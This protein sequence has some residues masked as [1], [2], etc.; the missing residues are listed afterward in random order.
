MTNILL[1]DAQQ[2]KT[3]AATRS[4]GS[5]GLNVLAGENTRWNPTAF[6]KYCT[7]GL[8][9][10][11]PKVNPTGFLTW[12]QQALMKLQCEVLLPMD[13]VT[14]DIVMQHQA[15][16]EEQ[17]KLLLP[18]AASFQTAG[19]KALAAKL[20]QHAGIPCPQT[21]APNREEDLRKLD[22]LVQTMKFPVVLKPRKSSGSR[23]ITVVWQ[24]TDLQAE[25]VKLHSQ[26]PYPLIQEYISPGPRYDVCLLYN[27]SSEL[28][29]S[30]VQRELRHFP[31]E[32][33]PSTLQESVWRPDLV[34]QAHRLMQELQ[35]QG[36]AE[37]EFMQDSRDGTLKFM[38]INPRFW[39]SLH[40]AIL[41]GVDFPWLYYR[42][43]IGAE[44]E[45]VTSYATG[46]RCRWLLPGDIL[47]FLTNPERRK[48]DPPI[49]AGKKQAVFDDILAWSDPLPTLGFC[50]AVLHY[51]PNKA[52]W[53]LMFER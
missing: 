22:T 15:E 38:E 13:D 26:Y 37:V 36:I 41:A 18:S 45:T 23:G 12:L 43:C 50:L 39:G 53:S 8:V 14:L 6:S 19:D 44:I 42:L 46:V 24:R 10:P 7:K 35:W 29:A 17:V 32:R 34:E 25:Y 20:A 11:D 9:Y 28:K 30:F 21:V 5:K 33:G 4:L 52:M 16:L 1:T 47:H 27:K 49:F 31:L 2:R 48:M 51:L 3:L 40:L